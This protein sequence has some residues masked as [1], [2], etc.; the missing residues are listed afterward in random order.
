MSGIFDKAIARYLALPAKKK[1]PASLILYA[2]A[3]V[4]LAWVL[5]KLRRR[6]PQPMT[7]P[8]IGNLY[9]LPQPGELPGV[10]KAMRQLSAQ[11]GPVMGCWFGGV[12]TVV[13]SNWRAAYEALKVR[14]DDFAGRFCPPAIN[15]ITK[16]KGIALQNDLGTWHKARS[17]LQAGLTRKDVHSDEVVGVM[18]EE[19]HSTGK[20]FYEKIQA[21]TTGSAEVSVRAYMG[22]E[23]LN[24]Y[25]RQMCGVRFS[26]KMTSKYQDVRACL[27]NIFQ[28]ISGGNPADYI[29]LLKLA[30]RPKILDEMEEWSDKMYKHIRGW[31]QEHKQD[32]KADAPRDFLD[33][34]LIKH[35]ELGLSEVDVEVIVWDVLAGGIDT[36]AT[37]M[38]WLMYIMCN[39][40]ETQRKCQEELDRVVG[41]DRLPTFKDRPNLPYLNAVLLELLR[42]KHFAPFGLPHMTLK[43]TE[44]LGYTIPAGAQIF[45]DFSAISLDPSA[46]KD[47]EKWRPERFLEEEKDL[48]QS[49]PNGIHDALF[50]DVKPTPES[51]KMIPFGAGKRKCVGT[52]IGRVVLWCKAATYLHCFNMEAPKGKMNIDDEFFGVTIMPHEQ[53]VRV[54]ARPAARLLQSC[55]H[56]FKGGNI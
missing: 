24:V 47:P 46:W 45:I 31:I 42:W 43:D 21:S 55:E 25:M 36:T 51:H 28:R 34:M 16:G 56:T 22:R 14:G 44:V 23:S 13:L 49:G 3:R 53:P 52:G 39:Y 18:L 2:L 10:H 4:A 32:L 40:P 5:R 37:T 41:K 30:G 27:E 33:V 48:C 15:T 12:Y 8:L 19:I 35:K 29:P 50:G 26:D 54:K 1:I 11:H 20:E 7:L 9:L 6:P 17:L 38:E